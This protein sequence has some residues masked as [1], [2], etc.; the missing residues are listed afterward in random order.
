MLVAWGTYYTDVCLEGLRKAHKISIRAA[1]LQA[2]VVVAVL[3]NSEIRLLIP[4][5]NR[6]D[7]YYAHL[8]STICIKLFIYLFICPASFYLT[9]VGVQNYCCM[10]LHIMTHSHSG[11]FPWTSDQPVEDVYVKHQTQQKSNSSPC[12]IRIRNPSKRV[13]TGLRLRP[14][15]HWNRR[16]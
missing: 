13:A 7:I 6:A 1:G 15:G 14:R 2:R 10:R 3:S 8:S 5:T 9:I 4:V 11:G 12:S 16:F